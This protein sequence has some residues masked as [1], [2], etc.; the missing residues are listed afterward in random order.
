MKEK[1]ILLLI[2]LVSVP[3]FAVNGLPTPCTACTS[4]KLGFVTAGTVDKPTI[5][6]NTMTINQKTPTAVLNWQNFNI[7][8]GHTV[9]FVQ[10]SST[11]SALNEIW[12]S[13]PT[14]IAGRLNA[15]GQIYLINQNGIVFAN[16]AQVNVNGLIASSLNFRD[17]DASKGDSPLYEAGYL[18]N[19]LSNTVSPVFTGSTGFVSVDT[20]AVLNGSRIMMFAPIVENRGSINTADGQAVLAAGT[21][22]YL[23]ASQDPNLRGVLVEVDMKNLDANGNPT[24]DPNAKANGVQNN[25]SGTASN[26]GSMLSQRGNTTLVGYAVNQQ[27]IIS[28]TTSVT[29]N[30]SIKLLARHTVDTS[31]PTVANDN[32]NT[33]YFDI[34]ATQAGNVTLG[35]NSVTEVLPE[36]ADNS[37]TTD[38]QGFNPSIIEVM[39]KTVDVQGKIIAPGGKV[40]LVAVGSINTTTS[41]TPSQNINIYQPITTKNGITYS[42]FLSPYYI[43]AVPS[44]PDGS[45][46]VLE[47]GSLV[48][49]SG[50]ST[51]VSV[52]RNILAVQ[53]RGTEL[54]DSPLQRNGFLHGQTVYIDIRKGSQLANYSGEE[55]QI[56]RTVAERTSTGGQVN[57]LSTGQAILNPGSTVNISGGQVD[58]T[59]AFVNTTTLISSGAAYDISNAPAD[60]N[61]QAIGGTVTVSHAKWGVTESWTTMGGGSQ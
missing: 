43:P 2:M 39:G 38:S 25:V 35:K 20:G 23:E 53:L 12:D 22:V 11:A 33:A 13:S 27:G 16:G 31:Y 17:F 47:N 24:V 28:A 15:N 7:D 52:A 8:A 14:T 1:T 32:V 58:Y 49:V 40:N 3:A 51:S 21:S 44:T 6:G 45:S 4:A 48:D 37:T 30:G 61:Y 29:E 9:N 55:A 56:G 57:I 42:G 54:A 34:R 26:L 46:V 10:P 60:L 5:S 41:D 36:I 18:T 59:G 19:N 50:S